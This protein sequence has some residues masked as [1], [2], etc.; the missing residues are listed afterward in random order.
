MC[1]RLFWCTEIYLD[2]KIMILETCHEYFKSKTGQEDIRENILEPIGSILYN[3][4]YFYV[5]LICLYHVFL[6][7]IVVVNSVLLIKLLRFVPYKN[8]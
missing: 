1:L 3:E 5:W 8:L 4:M 6:I 7:F 2:S